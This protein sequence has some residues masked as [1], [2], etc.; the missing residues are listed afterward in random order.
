MKGVFVER[1]ELG[2]E[3]P[4]I[5]IKDC[6]DIAQH[7]TFAGSRALAEQP[8]AAEH[9]TV[10]QALL[11]NGWYIVGKL[12]MHELAFGMSGINEWSG[13]PLNPQDP[14]LITGGSS[15]GSA[16]AVGAGLMDAALGTDTGGSIRL[17]AACCAVH[18]FKPTFG[19]VSRKGLHPAE[20]SLDCVGPFARDMNTLIRV[21]QALDSSFKSEAAPESPRIALVRTDS[22]A[23]IVEALTQVLKKT[24]W[25]VEIVEL[26]LMREAFQAAVD[27]ISAETWAAFGH[28]TERGL[29][30]A[31]VEARLLQAKQTSSQALAHAE[32]IRQ[33]FQSHVES[34]LT[35]FDALVMPTLPRL[36]PSVERVRNGEPL[37]ELSA[38]V[39]PFN[40]SGHPALS[41]PLPLPGTR[42]KAGLQVIGALGDD[43]KVCAV[44][45]A[46]SQYL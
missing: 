46:L 40:L 35:Q 17:P 11:D 23:P 36:P 44:G 15:S 42:L 20:S 13:T 43:A 12:T 6:I 27:V 4:S 9:A 25:Q 34:T 31:D 14:T 8:P 41:M 5:G 45:K 24:G 38:L 37:L 1:F 10:V 22:D 3:G 18:G 28:F 19:R 2:G 33:R 32:E 30:G 26:P 16:V 29:L 7:V 39:R 21:M